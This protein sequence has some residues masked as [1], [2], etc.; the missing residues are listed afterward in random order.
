MSLFRHS[1]RDFL[2]PT[3]ARLC[4]TA[5]HARFSGK[6]P[7]RD[8]SGAH[9]PP[10]WARKTH[11]L[12]AAHMGEVRD[13]RGRGMTR[14]AA[15]LLYV[16]AMVAIILALDFTVLRGHFAARLAANTAIVLAFGIGWLLIFRRAQA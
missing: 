6:L 13:L 14:N 4:F 10:R 9:Q 2:C 1:V 3:A 15:L 12:P 5:A 8:D 11:L 7:F 16:A